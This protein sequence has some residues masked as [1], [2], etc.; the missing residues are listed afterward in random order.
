M[1]REVQYDDHG[2]VKSWELHIPELRR[3]IVA[4]LDCPERLY[5]AWHRS[6]GV[7]RLLDENGND[8]HGFP[9]QADLWEV[10]EYR[11]VWHSEGW[12]AAYERVSEDGT[13]ARA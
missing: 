10:R 5:V 1:R 11:R 4:I 13:E 12:S 7:H 3:P 2:R 6:A 9:P 8:S